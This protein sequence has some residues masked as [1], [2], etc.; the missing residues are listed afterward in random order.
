MQTLLNLFSNY[1]FILGLFSII[2]TFVI[3][4]QNALTLIQIQRN[5]LKRLETLKKSTK[6]NL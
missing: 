2:I 3:G 1:W 4:M 6:I 5:E